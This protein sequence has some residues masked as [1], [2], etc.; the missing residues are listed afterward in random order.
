MENNRFF[1]KKNIRNCKEIRDREEFTV[2]FART[3]QYQQSSIFLY[4][5][6]LNTH[7]KEKGATGGREGAGPGEG[8]GAGIGG[9]G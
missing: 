3:K 6:L 4:H 2:N 9:G 7:S 1:N 8:V 5:R